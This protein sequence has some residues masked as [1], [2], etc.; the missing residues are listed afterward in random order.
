MGRERIKVKKNLCT[1]LFL[2]F[3]QGCVIAKDGLKQGD[4]QMVGWMH[5]ELKFKNY[6]SLAKGFSNEASPQKKP[7]G[8]Y[9]EL[10]V[11]LKKVVESLSKIELINRYFFLFEPNPHLFL[12]LEVKDTNDF[13]SIKEK[14]E[15]IVR[16]NFI[17]SY[18]IKFNTGDGGHPEGALDLFCASAKYAFFRVSDNYKPGYNNN[19]ETKI[20][21]CFCNQLF[22][23]WGN[24]IKFYINGLFLRGANKVTVEMQGKTYS[25]ENK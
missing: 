6:D 19:D 15:K 4:R 8:S 10:I 17:D 11:Y 5:L 23:N 9:K 12:A 3:L 18:E 24:E 13:K 7:E 1:I 2:I 22:Y 21:H 20:I 25:F 16:P 14:I